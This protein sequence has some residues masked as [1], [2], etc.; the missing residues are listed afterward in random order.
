MHLKRISTILILVSVLGFT[1]WIV[2][3]FLLPGQGP[4][5]E[6]WGTQ[7][8]KFKVRVQRR[9]DLYSIMSY[10]YVFQTAQKG[11]IR[12]R[13]ITRHLYNEPDAL[14]KKQIRFVNE[15]VGYLF[16]QLKYAVTVD[17]GST[18]TVFDFGNNPLFKPQELDY[19]RIEDVDI[20]P[21]GTG[22][23]TMFKYDSSQ[24]K[25]TLFFT[26]DYGQHWSLKH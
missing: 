6:E 12:W 24:G 18:W 1:A 7:N 16:F 26:N 4:V 9:A 21:D 11:S 14:P 5:V 19:S 3:G 20:L 13:E 17:S 15:D 10:W 25:S 2:E 23:L 22:K 8:T